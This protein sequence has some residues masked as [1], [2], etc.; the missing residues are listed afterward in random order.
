[1]GSGAQNTSE[2]TA[3]LTL[4][5]FNAGQT[6]AAIEAHHVA[7]L[8]S[9]ASM[10]RFTNAECLLLNAQN[11]SVPPSRWLTLQDAQGPWQLGVAGEVVLAHV[12]ISVLYPLP[13]LIAARHESPALRGVMLKD[14]T[15]CLLF[16][17]AALNPGQPILPATES[18]SRLML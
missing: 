9:S 7:G 11:I 8:A 18:P 16:D 5:L 13:P 1:M 2:S 3:Y 4:V 12:A 10:Q 6:L 14:Q 17:G 15:L